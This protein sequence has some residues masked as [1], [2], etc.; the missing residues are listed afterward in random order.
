MLEDRIQQKKQEMVNKQLQPPPL[1]SKPQSKIN[2]NHKSNMLKRMKEEVMHE[3]DEE[4]VR[5]TSPM[6]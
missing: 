5:D 3:A 1:Q 6:Q 2:L 4:N